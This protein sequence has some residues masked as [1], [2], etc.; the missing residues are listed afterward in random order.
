[1][2]SSL[3][4]TK[5]SLHFAFG[6][7]ANSAQRFT[8][9]SFFF[10][11]DAAPTEIYPLPLPGLLP[12]GGGVPARCLSRADTSLS[13]PAIRWLCA[14]TGQKCIEAQGRRDR[15]PS[16]VSVYEPTTWV[17]SVR[18]PDRKSTRLNSSHSQISYAV[19]CLKK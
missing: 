18:S 11:N 16:L 6:Y 8:S 19:F 3:K 7:L 10:L 9:S 17:G 15:R 13:R 1:M 5:A 2:S 14:A 12:I 4:K